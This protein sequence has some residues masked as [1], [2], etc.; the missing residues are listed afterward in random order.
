MNQKMKLWHYTTRDRV[1]EIIA[2]GEIRTSVAN[3]TGQKESATLWMSSN[4]IWENTATKL[5]SDGR[6]IRQLSKTEQH[7]CFG[8]GRIE[9][10]TTNISFFTWLTFTKNIAAKRHI[11][12]EM[13]KTGRKNG[14]NPNQWYGSTKTIS[15]D[16]FI[17]AEI[18]DGTDWEVIQTAF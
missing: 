3:R 1:T 8:L 13:E 18:W 9:V 2:S 17:S 10:D 5:V 16:A 6:N 15:K 14:G 4:P 7:E 12:R 11:A